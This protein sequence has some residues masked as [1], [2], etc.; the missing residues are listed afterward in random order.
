MK[1]LWL[2]VFLLGSF[3]VKAQSMLVFNDAA[4]KVN[5]GRFIKYAVQDSSSKTITGVD[6]V[7]RWLT[8]K[9]SVLN[10]GVSNN[11][12]WLRL[13]IKNETQQPRLLL[14]VK[15][16]LLDEVKFFQKDE[17]G[18]FIEQEADQKRPFKLRLI[19]NPN[20]TF[21]LNVKEHTVKT[22][23]LLVKSNSELL[24]PVYLGTTENI[25]ESEL[26]R[27]LL[28]GIYFGVIIVSIF[29]NLFIALS[30][31]DRSYILYIFYILLVGL[32]QAILGGYS[33]KYLWP[34]FPVIARQSI[35]IIPALNS[36][37]VIEF[38]R[39]FVNT[40]ELNKRANFVLKIFNAVYIVGILISLTGFDRVS[41]T[42][43]LLADLMGAVY[44]IYIS[45][46]LTLKKYSQA[47]FFLVAW[48]FF[49]VSIC[50]FVLRNFNILPFNTFTEYILL[51]GSGA[52]VT[53]LSF[54]LADRINVLKKEKDA[55]QQVALAE[56]RRNEQLIMDQNTTL[57][58]TV[59]KRT[60]ELK[61][62]WQELNTTMEHLKNAQSQLVESEKMASLG[63]LT[64]GIA[65]EINNPINFVTSNI[66]PLKRDIQDIY[67]LLGHYENQNGAMDPDFKLS[68]SALKKELDIDYVK[69]EIDQLLQGIDEGANRTSEIIRGLKTFSRVDEQ[70]IKDVDLNKGFESTL[71][72]LNSKIKDHI[73]L[74]LKLGNLPLVEC[75]AGK[76]NQVFMN[77]ISNSIYAITKQFEDEP[78]GELVIETSYDALDNGQVKVRI[79]DNGTGMPEEIRSKIFDPFFTT[80]PVGEGTGLGLSIV[81]Q[82][83]TGHKGTIH[84][85]SSPGKGTEFKIS[86]PV[87]QEKGKEMT[88]K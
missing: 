13:T 45:I 44:I 14:E 54:A 52:E 5:C 12:Y 74:N 68:V 85:K 21:D 10:L 31:N 70:D 1:E 67:K 42:M 46:D 88:T 8:K 38:F 69:N 64:A 24:I 37:A 60:V 3:E 80:K 63:Q 83:I 48:S 82:I 30:V 22:V 71:L 77:I 59:E 18:T 84:V 57:E 47:R 55:S 19:Q 20:P 15:F 79:A 66:N 32:S 50:V 36:I 39:V 86:L 26:A 27:N 75:Y 65:H 9:E 11:S 43:I 49:L 34:S 23:F 25:V 4:S 61:R 76:L 33:Y 81:Q 56:L 58:E 7:T 28:Y 53:L 35:N 2:V 51:I 62:A 73:K 6:K 87:Y 29:Y 72:L 17:R 41:Y 16:P 40:R 78:G